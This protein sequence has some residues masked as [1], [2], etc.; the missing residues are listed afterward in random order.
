MSFDEVRATEALLDAARLAAECKSS[1]GP[2]GPLEV[3]VRFGP[4]GHVLR[5]AVVTAEF[6]GS[7]AAKCVEMVFR[8]AEVPEF[9]GPAPPLFQRIDIL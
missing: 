1:T 5:A 9:D 2:K 3:G 6:A 7:V 4:N 8:R